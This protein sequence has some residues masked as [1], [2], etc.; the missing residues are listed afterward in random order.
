MNRYA[1]LIM[2][3]LVLSACGGDKAATEASTETAAASADYE[4]GPNRGRML[5][6]GDFALEITVYETNTPPHLAPI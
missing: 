5:R 3:P 6:D 4:R 1:F 2:F